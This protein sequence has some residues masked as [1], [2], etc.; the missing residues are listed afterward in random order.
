MNLTDFFQSCNLLIYNS[1]V[2]F[3]IT[4]QIEKKDKLYIL[5]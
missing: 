2:N 1:E 3:L 5:I 4:F